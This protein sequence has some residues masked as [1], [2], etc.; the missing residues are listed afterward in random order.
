MNMSDV[1]RKRK[2]RIYYGKSSRNAATQY[3]AGRPFF[4]GIDFGSFVVIR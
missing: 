1:I 4:D 3:A 2:I